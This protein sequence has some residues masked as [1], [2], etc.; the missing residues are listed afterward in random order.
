MRTRARFPDVAPEAG[1]YESFYLKASAPEGGRAIWIRHTVHKRPGAQPTC[2]VWMT[3]FDEGHGAPR[4]AKQQ[5]GADSLRIP[6]DSY[7]RV[8]DS[9]IGAGWVRG[10]VAGGGVSSR[11]GLRFTDRHE[12]LRHLPA[13]WMYDA[14]LPRTKLLS[15][16]P[17]ALFD[18]TFDIDDERVEISAWPGMVGHNWGAE[19]AERWIWIHGTGLDGGAET[20]FLDIAAGRVRLGPLRTPWIANGAICVDGERF[21]LGGLGR[22]ARIDAGPRGCRFTVGGRGVSVSGTVGGD[23]DQFV[24]WLYSDP[25][26]GSHHAL[27]CSISDLEVTVK[28]RGRPDARRRLRRG[29]A[30]ELGSHDTDHGVPLQPFDDG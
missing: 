20:D 12:A 26:G 25:G 21:R 23:R 16:H 6:N 28:R 5:F 10:N 8:G 29:A 15:P 13:A 19:H 7:V 27:N 18:G 22:R 4:A 24:A 17:G 11:W 9:E 2:A 3:Y 30:Y 14:K 1:H